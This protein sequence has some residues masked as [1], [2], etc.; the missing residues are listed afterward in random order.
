MALS[1]GQAQ[2]LAI[3]RAILKDA[4]III[5]DEPTSQ[6]DVETEAALH[7]A[8]SRLTQGKTVLLIAHRLSTIEQADRI[9]VMEDGSVI[10]SGT[11]EELLAEDGVYAQMVRTKRQSEGDTKNYSR[12]RVG[13]GNQVMTTIDAF[14]QTGEVPLAGVSNAKI[15]SRL[16]TYMKPFNLIMFIS[17]AARVI[18]NRVS[19]SR[20]WHRGRKCWH[21][22][23]SL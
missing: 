4:P 9:V 14:D 23:R 18:K 15:I 1:G 8:L 5:L 22:H 20:S 21:L 19:S 17:L 13:E 2:R 12:G 7:R 6:I 11:R 16:L 3:A 10:E